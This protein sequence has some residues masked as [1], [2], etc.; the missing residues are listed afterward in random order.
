MTAVD[1]L[2]FAGWKLRR[3]L[4]RTVDR[5]SRCINIV[6]TAQ[7]FAAKWAERY[8]GSMYAFVTRPHA[9]QFWFPAEASSK[10]AADSCTQADIEIA[11]AAVAGMFDIL[12]SGPTHVGRRPTWR[13]DLYSGAEWPL[14]S[15]FTMQLDRGDGSDIRTTWEMSRCYHFIPLA[16]AYWSTNNPV[17]RDA[18]VDHVESFI[19]NNPVGYGP[20]WLS[21]MDVA[22]R[23]ANWI[24][25]AQLFA[26]APG[27]SG[28]VWQSLVAELYASGLYLARYPEWNPRYRGNHYV[29]DAVGQV[30]LGA[31]FRDDMQGTRWLQ[32]GAHILNAEIERQ[33]HDDGVSF[34]ASLAYHRLATE[35]FIAGGDVVRRNG[36]EALGPH[37]DERLRLMRVFI[38]AY[39]PASGAAPM[40]GD[41]DDGR[42]H[43][44]CAAS[45]DAPREHKRGMVSESFTPSTTTSQAFPQ[46]GFYVMRRND[47]HLIIRCGAVGLNGA[48]SHDHN[49]QLSFELCIAGRRVV[50]DSGCYAYTRDLQARY[51]FRSTAA[52]STIQLGNEEQNPI[53][54]DRPWRILEERTRAECTHWVA[55]ASETRFIGRHHGYSHRASGAILQRTITE[56]ANEGWSI[57]DEILGNDVEDVF[58]RLHLAEAVS[59]TERRGEFMLGSDEFLRI[60]IDAPSSLE[61]EVT[62]TE[63]SDRYGTKYWR[64]C[65]VAHGTASLP[66]VI[67]TK[68][69]RSQEQ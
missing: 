5:A 26:N 46:G 43:A 38:E 62:Q 3:H 10:W 22:L 21:P 47:D 66:A 49:D 45:L 23:A 17:Y 61:F 11:D 25:G 4:R 37:Y 40:M 16:R 32:H 67:R 60:V 54:V 2:Q 59:P 27:I 42:V 33:V 8:D 6:T 51:A 29:A 12:G 30:Y 14:Q 58:W 55:D 36:P 65:I 31:F 24:V 35:L 48:G 28:Q 7:L 15:S 1:L 44:V 39:L 57:E 56:T 64:P 13:V 20:N 68:F 41:A 52:H 63:A 34:E 18:F 53:R 50:S 69:I 9:G 19:E